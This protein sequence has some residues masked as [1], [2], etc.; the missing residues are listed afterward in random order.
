MS[1]IDD[2]KREKVR[3]GEQMAVDSLKE[4]GISTGREEENKPAKATPPKDLRERI[5]NPNFAKNEQEWW[6]SQ[7]IVELEKALSKSLEAIIFT[8]EYVGDER[9]PPISGWSWFDAG[10][11]ISELIP[12]DEW[13]QQFKLRVK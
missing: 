8:R 9:L 1:L 7:R 10:N 12:D 6:A 5:M 11:M 13:V 2:I 3:A 4:M